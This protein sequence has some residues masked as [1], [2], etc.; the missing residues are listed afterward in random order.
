MFAHIEASVGFEGR[1]ETRMNLLPDTLLVAVQHRHQHLRNIHAVVEVRMRQQELA[2]T[3]HGNFGDLLLLGKVLLVELL[4]ALH[5]LCK[6]FAMNEKLFVLKQ[7]LIFIADS[8]QSGF[9]H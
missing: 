9:L 6:P 5:L 4:A 1:N 3:L 2:H 7:Q 8:G